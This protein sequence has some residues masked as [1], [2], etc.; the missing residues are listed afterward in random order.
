ML[1]VHRVVHVGFAVPYVRIIV[2][3]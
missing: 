2:N 1:K 3:V